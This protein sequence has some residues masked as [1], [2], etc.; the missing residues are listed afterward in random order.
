VRIR[1]RHPLMVRLCDAG[2]PTG[3][4]CRHDGRG[5]GE[6]RITWYTSIQNRHSTM[7]PATQ[8]LL[9]CAGVAGTQGQDAPTAVW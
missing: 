8:H 4:R 7:A 5:M 6:Q 3:C 2:R 9:E 1:D